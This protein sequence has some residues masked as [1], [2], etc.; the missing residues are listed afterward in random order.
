SI[1]LHEAGHFATAK[2]FG[3]KATQFF[4][5]FGRTI[6][7]RRK[8]ETEYGV[9]AIP[10]G[11]F[12]KIVGLTE[13]EG[14]DP[15]DEPRSVRKEPGWQRMIVLAAGWF[16]H[17][18]LALVLLFV[19]AAGIGLETGSAGTTVAAVESCVP[20]N[21]QAGCAKGDP[22]SPAAKAGIRAG[23]KI[24]SVGGIRVNSWGQMG[25]AIRAQHPGTAVPGGVDRH[26]QPVRQPR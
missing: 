20:A 25:K 19:I 8:G 9:K 12:V 5:G 17:F 18:G 2:M 13:L 10:A 21:V 16:M 26:C 11:G 1:M 23:D 22:K 15:A 24:V 7:S 14:V 6:W 4:V 3:M